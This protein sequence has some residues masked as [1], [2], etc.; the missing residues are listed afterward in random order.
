MT[1]RCLTYEQQWPSWGTSVARCQACM[2]A[3][4][5]CDTVSYTYGKDKKT[6]L[7]VLMNNYID[8]LQNILGEPDISQG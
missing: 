4:S 7:K 6:A 5:G 8:G 2:H 3:L 1:A